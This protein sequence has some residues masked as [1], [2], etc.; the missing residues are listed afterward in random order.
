MPPAGRGRAA[1]LPAH[2]TR[3]DKNPSPAVI[4]APVESQIKSRAE[5]AASI[6]PEHLQD[7]FIQEEKMKEES[8]RSNVVERK[9]PT[10][11]RRVETEEDVARREAKLSNI[12][13]QKPTSAFGLHTLLAATNPKSLISLD[14]SG[15]GRDRKVR[16][17]VSSVYKKVSMTKDAMEREERK[18]REEERRRE[19]EK[20]AIEQH[21]RELRYQ[22]RIMRDKMAVEWKK[23]D[24]VSAGMRDNYLMARVERHLYNDPNDRNK[25]DT[26]EYLGL[27]LKPLEDNEQ[28]TNLLTVEVFQL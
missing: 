7:K 26:L 9:R 6:L 11:K 1:T 5:A 15:K 23:E 22:E 21:Y 3:L 14:S 8:E 17:D 18:K 28:V 20:R 16:R 13:G 19:E 10:R 12:Y 24:T 4:A 25:M 27:S 2:I